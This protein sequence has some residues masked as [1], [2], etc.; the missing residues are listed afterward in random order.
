MSCAER[1]R[2]LKK[3]LESTFGR[4]KVTCRGSRGT[5]YGWVRVHIAFAPRNHRE[6]QELRSQVSAL[7]KA[8]KI[9]L[10]RFYSD[11]YTDNTPR[12][13]IHID[14]DRCREQAE[15]HGPEAFK[16]HMS[17]ADWDAM[18]ARQVQA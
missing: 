8:A 7:I 11:D 16:Q 13:C 2:N 1:N 17:A 12:D 9:E 4:G 6:A 10:G 18:Q 15:G 5:S 14:F 3:L